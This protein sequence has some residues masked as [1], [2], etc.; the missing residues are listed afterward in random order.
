MWV[1]WCV[2]REGGNRGERRFQKEQLSSKQGEFWPPPRGTSLSH[3]RRVVRS[4][5]QKLR[6]VRKTDGRQLASAINTERAFSLSNLFLQ[7]F[8]L[9]I[10]T[11]ANLQISVFWR[12]QPYYCHGLKGEKIAPAVGICNIHQ[13]SH[14]HTHT[15]WGFHGAP[16]SLLD[17]NELRVSSW[18]RFS[19]LLQEKGKF[20]WLCWGISFCSSWLSALSQRHRHTHRG[21]VRVLCLCRAF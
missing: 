16:T 3:F 9:P 21:C 17:N 8:L 1:S 4:R 15:H 12:L 19:D 10:S 6:R 7:I 2:S 11:R 18:T 5:D 14:T 13:L 20:R